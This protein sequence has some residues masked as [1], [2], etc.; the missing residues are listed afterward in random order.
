MLIAKKWG[1]TMPRVEKHVVQGFVDE[2]SKNRLCIRRRKYELHVP[3]CNLSKSIIFNL[4]NAHAFLASGN[5]LG[6][7]ETINLEPSN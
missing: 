2:R 1:K 6:V 3:Q 7:S 5:F 4:K